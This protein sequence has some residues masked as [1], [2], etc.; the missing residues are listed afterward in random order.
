MKQQHF[1]LSSA[2][3]FKTFFN[4]CQPQCTSGTALRIANVIAISKT[5][6]H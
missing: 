4:V 1:T 2:N 6:A 3:F 5:V